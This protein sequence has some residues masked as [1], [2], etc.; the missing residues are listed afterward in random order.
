MCVYF[1]LRWHA[2]C[3]IICQYNYG[4]NVS[5]RHD[6]HQQRTVC[7]IGRNNCMQLCLGRLAFSKHPVLQSCDFALNARALSLSRSSAGSCSF[8]PGFAANLILSW[9]L[10]IGRR[11]RHPAHATITPALAGAYFAHTCCSLR[12]AARCCFCCCPPAE[13]RQPAPRDQHMA[14]DQCNLQR[15]RGA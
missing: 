11:S 9:T 12:G 3:A 2:T 14:V 6:A 1:S 13:H 7:V 5:Q 15:V 8:Q 4:M 10:G